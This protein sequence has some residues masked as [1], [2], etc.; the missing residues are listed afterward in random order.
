MEIQAIKCMI[1]NN[2]IFSRAR[3]DFRTCECGNV[4]IDGGFDYTKVSVGNG[5]YVP[6]Q[7]TIDNVTEKILYDDWNTAKD[8]YGVIK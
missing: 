5:E 8:K 6:V 4:S 2:T 1:C 3:H 7:L